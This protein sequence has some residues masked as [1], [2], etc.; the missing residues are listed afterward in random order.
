MQSKV[1]AC[2]PSAQTCAHRHNSSVVSAALAHRSQNFGDFYVGL[3]RFVK[4]QCV[5]PWPTR[6][7]ATAIEVGEWERGLRD[8][9]GTWRSSWISLSALSSPISHVI[10]WSDKL[11]TGRKPRNFNDVNSKFEGVVRELRAKLRWGSGA[12]RG[13]GVS[14]ELSAALC[15]RT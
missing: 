1:V 9:R 10:R 13:F 6:G 12:R 15:G 11:T 7:M 3:C 4:R 2:T 5:R 8:R 14:L